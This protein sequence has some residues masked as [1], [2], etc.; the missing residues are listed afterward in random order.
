MDLSLSWWF[1]VQHGLELPSTLMS[2]NSSSMLWL[3]IPRADRVFHLLQL[4][5]SSVMSSAHE[6]DS[7]SINLQESSVPIIPY[8]WR[9]MQF[10]GSN[11][12]CLERIL[13]QTLLCWEGVSSI[14][15]SPSGSL[16]F[17]GKEAVIV[18]L[19]LGVLFSPSFQ[20]P[21]SLFYVLNEQKGLIS[22]LYSIEGLLSISWWF[23]VQRLLNLHSTLIDLELFITSSSPL[24]VVSF[25][26]AIIQTTNKRYDHNLSQFSSRPIEAPFAAAFDCKCWFSSPSSLYLWA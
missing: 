18:Y 17:G 24:R 15:G 12:S 21:G 20:W 14:T 25:S 10:L 11:L 5:D 8:V 6:H 23:S 9:K 16:L 19:P 13:S 26:L 2:S 7:S 4:W 22:L 1:G 3:S